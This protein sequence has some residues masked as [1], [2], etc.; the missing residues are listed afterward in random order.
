MG[1]GTAGRDIDGALGRGAS[2]GSDRGAGTADGAGVEPV[3]EPGAPGG[4]LA[5]RAV[6]PGPGEPGE[7]AGE[8]EKGHH[9]RRSDAANDRVRLALPQSEPVPEASG[10]GTEQSTG[11]RH[12]DHVG[13]AREPASERAMARSSVPR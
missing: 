3:G 11:S 2:A 12:G 4:A 8:T 9:Q 5:E 1:G 6:D 7:H 13:T 10:E